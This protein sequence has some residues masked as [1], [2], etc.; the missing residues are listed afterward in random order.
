MD[1]SYLTLANKVYV[2]DR[3]ELDDAFADVVRA[4]N[5]EMDNIDFIDNQKAADAINAW[6]SIY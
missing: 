5:S 3:Y 4:F 6:V 1:P 2:S